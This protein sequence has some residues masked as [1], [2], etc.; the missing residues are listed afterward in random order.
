[1]LTTVAVA[2]YRS[3]QDLRIRLAPITVVAGANG[4]GR[5]GLYR[6][7][8]LISLRD[9]VQSWRFYDDFLSAALG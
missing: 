5:S 2:N 4:V 3:L 6:A 9:E 7:P 8:Q 1:M